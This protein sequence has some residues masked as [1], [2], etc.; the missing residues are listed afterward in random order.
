MSWRASAGYEGGA[1][2]RAPGKFNLPPSPLLYF[3]FPLSLSLKKK[4]VCLRVLEDALVLPG[5]V[6][7]C[8]S[9][10]EECFFARIVKFW[11][12]LV[13]SLER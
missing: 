2:E 3:F 8:F 11:W 6:P 12:G 7:T 4:N 5:G 10:P 9:V 13:F 1:F